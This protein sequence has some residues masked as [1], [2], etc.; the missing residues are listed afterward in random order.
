MGSLE[1]AGGVAFVTEDAAAPLISLTGAIGFTR[2]VLFVNGSLETD[3]NMDI[4]GRELRT[5]AGGA[6]L[7]VRGAINLFRRLTIALA[8]AAIFRYYVVKRDDL[9]GAARHFW[10][11]FGFGVHL[12]VHYQITRLLGVFIQPG[13]AI[14]P[15]ARTVRIE[16]G[17]EEKIGQVWLPIVAGISFSF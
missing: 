9:P 17:P 4:D 8:G 3:S 7:G 14:F 10:P 6:S 2:L 15:F 13:A 16:D 12:F 5:I 1:V 11:D